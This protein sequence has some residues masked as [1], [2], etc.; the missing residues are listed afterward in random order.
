MRRMHLALVLAAVVASVAVADIRSQSAVK[1][2]SECKLAVAKARDAYA[3]SL[4]KALS[5]AM[6]RKDLE[7]SVAINDELKRLAALDRGADETTFVA[8]ESDLAGR[9]FDYHTSPDALLTLRPDGVVEC[10]RKDFQG[11]K[12]WKL[13]GQTLRIFGP[14]KTSLAAEFHPSIVGE[15]V[16]WIG[17]MAESGE[18]RLLVQSP[19]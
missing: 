12:F 8:R 7:E 11:E 13:D 16:F 4:T 18:L 2:R 3:T 5:A 17:N 10:N 14:E 6:D 1:A 9:R 15:R 19:H